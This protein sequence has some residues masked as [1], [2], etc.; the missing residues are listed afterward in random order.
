VGPS[1]W[2]VAFLLALVILSM[3][4]KEMLLDWTLIRRSAPELQRSL[5][6][7]NWVDSSATAVS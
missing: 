5:E 4:S 7:P 6:T 3:I 1:F 2:E